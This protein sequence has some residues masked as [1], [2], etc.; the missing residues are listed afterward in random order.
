VSLPSLVLSSL[1]IS[2][3]RYLALDPETLS[4]LGAFTGKVI[5]VELRGI[6]I[7]L[8][9]APHGGGIQLLGDYSGKPDTVI[10]GAPW[11]LARTGYGG[12]RGALFAGEVE[13]RGDVALGQRFEA[14]L[15]EI[16]ID[17]EEQLSRLVGD[18]AAHQVGKLVRDT[19]TWG[20]N[21]VDTLSR[22]VGEYLQEESRQLPQR[23]EVDAFLGA[24]DHLR[25]DV[26]RLEARVKRLHALIEAGNDA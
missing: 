11:S 14:V 17:W 4:R 12:D 3:N 8:A 15:R 10:S 2:V 16:D 5:S 24:V 21:S 6:G 18:V 22:D 26:A 25:D 19:M 1:E 13:I 9:M 23:D 7:T 20:A